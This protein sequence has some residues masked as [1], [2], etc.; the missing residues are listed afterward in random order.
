[1]RR[2]V[3]SAVI[4][5]GDISKSVRADCHLEEIEQLSRRWVS[6]KRRTENA[7][8]ANRAHMHDVIASLTHC[9]YRFATVR[10][11]RLREKDIPRIGH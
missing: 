11:E 2:V 9:E 1:M 7:D 6:G 4:R 5:K 10:V 8:I 3:S